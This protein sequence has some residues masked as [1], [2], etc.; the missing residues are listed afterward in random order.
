[1]E[2]KR[3]ADLKKW[4]TEA[5]EGVGRTRSWLRA[6]RKSQEWHKGQLKALRE[7][8][9]RCEGYVGEAEARLVEA[10]QWLKEY[11]QD[12]ASKLADAEPGSRNR[13]GNYLLA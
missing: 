6:T 2:D 4:V 13:D 11:E 8:E 5:E 1:M 3:H 9:K 12:V 7:E 10:R